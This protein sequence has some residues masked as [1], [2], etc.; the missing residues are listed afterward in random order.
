MGTE[1]KTNRHV[2]TK[3]LPLVVAGLGIGWL[4]G[5]SVSPVVGT[6]LTSIL[7]AVAGVVAGLTILDMEKPKLYNPWPVALLILG[8]ALG[9]PLGILARTNDL[10]GPMFMDSR[11]TVEATAAE[12]PGTDRVLNESERAAL[13]ALFSIGSENCTRLLGSPNEFLPSALRTSQFPWAQ[14]LANEF[15]DDVEMMRHMVEILCEK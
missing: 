13:S 15:A 8:I 7:G 12:T 9:S 14:R 1:K 6:V 4:T 11:G 10:F 3:G 5:L 2:R